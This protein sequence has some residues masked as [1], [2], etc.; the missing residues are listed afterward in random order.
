MHSFNVNLGLH[1]YMYSLVESD[2][3]SLCQK[4]H[5][6]GVFFLY[7]PLLSEEIVKF[8]RVVST[9]VLLSEDSL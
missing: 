7:H 8:A 9:H 3:G 6:S 4:L 1:G 2:L 5:D